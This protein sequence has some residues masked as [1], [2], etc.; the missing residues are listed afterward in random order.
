MS[1]KSTSYQK[2]KHPIQVVAAR[3]GLSKDVIRVWERRYQA[4]T[5]GRSDTGRR[6][7]ADTDI[8]RLLVLKQLTDNGWRIG[9]VAALPDGE[10]QRLREQIA[11]APESA[12]SKRGP[13][14]ESSTGESYLGRC[15]AAVEA[16]DPGEL[17]S[18]LSA[19]SVAMSMP[20][21]LDDLMAPLLAEIGARWHQGDLRVGHEHLATSV[22]RA[23]LDNLRQSANMGASGPTILVTTPSGQHHEM[24][25]QMAAVAAAN[26]GWKAVYLAPSLPARDIAAAVAHLDAK[27]LALSLT[28]PADDL[29]LAAELRFLRQHLPA[30]MPLIVGGQAAAAYRATLDEIGAIF[31]TRFTAIM[32][33]LGELR[34]QPARHPSTD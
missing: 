27:A 11:S 16:M 31:L 14:S 33:V 5:P 10:L 17:E 13:A 1:D 3:T 34:A 15:L 4:V 25:A 23:F 28:F 12:V 29:H 9:D 30:P 2:P 20:R 8:D 21:L 32:D 26:A 18:L 6:L 7:F 22:I 24:G 19:A